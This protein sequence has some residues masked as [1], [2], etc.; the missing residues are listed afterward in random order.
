MGHIVL[1]PHSLSRAAASPRRGTMARIAF[2]YAVFK[3]FGSESSS[4]AAAV[5]Y[6]NQCV[7]FL[8]LRKSLNVTKLGHYFHPFSDSTLCDFIIYF[9]VKITIKQYPEISR[10]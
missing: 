6:Q 2:R 3:N 10:D 5:D 9:A 1:I 4:G 7:C 8:H